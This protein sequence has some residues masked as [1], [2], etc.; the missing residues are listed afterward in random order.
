MNPFERLM[1]AV[2]K[3]PVDRVPLIC[4]GGMMTMAV[5]EAMD[6]LRASWPEAHKDAGLMAD[7]TEGMTRLGGIENL[8]VPFCMTIEA[9]SMGATVDLGNRAREPHVTRYVM[10]SMADTG[11]LRPLDPEKGRAAVCCDAIRLLKK[12]RTDLPLIGNL[13]GPVSLATSLV[14]P[15]S[16]YRAVRRDKPRV[17]ELTSFCVEQAIVLGDAMVSAGADMICIADP[18]ATGDLLG[19]SAFEEFVLPCLNRMTRHFQ[20]DLGVPVIV[21]ICGDIKKTGKLLEKLEARVI[22]VDSVVGISRLSHLIPEK[23]TMGNVS[24]YT[25]ER[26]SPGKVERAGLSCLRQGVDILAPACGISPLTPLTNIQSL[27]KIQTGLK[28]EP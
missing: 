4:P 7:L 18:S 24:T 15:I 6:L 1:K 2:D 21:H 14:E 27:A 3:E 8:G 13:S 22:S 26:G 5:S 11:V 23:V 28:I 10:E 25:L 20:E 17:Y 16:Y 12:R 9:E 19:P